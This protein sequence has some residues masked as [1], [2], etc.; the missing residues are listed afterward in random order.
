MALHTTIKIPILFVD[1]EHS[2]L[3]TMKRTFRMQQMFQLYTAQTLAEAWDV[4][5][6]TTIDILIT[7]YIMPELTGI[8]FARRV[9]QQF[10][11]I[12]IFILT[13]HARL[14]AF[15]DELAKLALAGVI[16]KPWDTTELF[17]TLIEAYKSKK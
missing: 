9:Q 17:Q 5:K 2:V 14:P 8:E 11:H 6:N 7:D 4:L 15:Q 1:D 12:L 16:S 3:N 10:P 13:G